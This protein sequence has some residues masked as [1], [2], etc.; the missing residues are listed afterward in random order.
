MT[1]ETRTVIGVDPGPTPGVVLLSLTGAAAGVRIIG[2][3]VVQ[4][5]AGALSA[6]L[7]ALGA[8]DALVAVERYVVGARSGRSAT[9]G[10]GETTR[11]QVGALIG[12]YPVVLRNAGQV[13]PWATDARL[14]AAGLLDL[15]KGMRHTRDA[16]RHALFTACKD[17]GLPDP[18]STRSAR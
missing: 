1:A 2:R 15:C 17:A 11:D 5:S 9:A 3:E 12:A 16:A 4:C 7:E 10:A 13:K 6:V 18:L 14:E 8:A